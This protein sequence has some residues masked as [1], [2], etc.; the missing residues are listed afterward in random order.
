MDAKAQS[1]KPKAR[2]DDSVVVFL[3]LGSN[4]GDR[5]ANLRAAVDRLADLLDVEAVSSIY[6][7][8]PVGYT[9]QPDFLNLALRART[10]LPP[11]DLMRELIDV[12]RALGRE[13][14]FPN[15]PRL[16]DIDVLL[17]G[18][19]VIDMPELV[20]PH[21]RMTARA[22]TLLPLLE[23]NPDLVHPGSGERLSDIATRTPLERAQRLG[24]LGR[25]AARVVAAL[26]VAL[27]AVFAACDGGSG[28]QQSDPELD[29][30]VAEVM[31]RIERATGMSSRAPVRAQRRSRTE[32]REYLE[33]R[34]AEEMPADE[35]ARTQQLYQELGL[36]PAGLDL[37]ALLLD[38]LTEQVV[39]YYDPPTKTFY[40]VEGA[41]DAAARE[42]LAHELVHALQ[43]QYVDLDSLLSP[44]LENDRATAAQ[45]AIEGHATLV[46]FALMLQERTGDAVDITSLPDIGRQLRP[47]LE[48]GNDRM[49]VFRDAPRIIR[50]TLI[51]PYIAGAGYVQAV[52][53]AY[54]GE[55]RPSFE[56]L[57]PASTEQV[58]HARARLAAGASADAPTRVALAGPSG[59]W[60]VVHEEVLGELELG[61]LL[62]QHIGSAGGD[63]ERA[64]AGWDGDVVRLVE[65]GL[66][67]RA[68]IIATVWD[69]ANDAAQFAD[70]YRRVL[71]ARGTRHGGVE[72]VTLEGR[73][74][75]VIVDAPTGVPR[76]LLPT[77]F[78]EALTQ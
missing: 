19:R 62:S 46:M 71:T 22:F 26:G 13:R 8:E 12:E 72:R 32:L 43:D 65:S 3:G 44:G 1:P 18:D 59:D 37:R 48:A 9:D 58:M 21:P 41:D 57:I 5:R 55:G 56:S 60:R 11:A 27:A 42:V 64:V 47:A 73:E 14:T 51:F 23:L 50:E 10:T 74:L 52:W 16:I 15:A 34:M 4:Q 40:L 36:L 68:I 66:G 17:Y 31:P 24:A 76:S 29:E 78:V 38:L 6:E 61:L 25:G 53:A 7:T 77:P 75:V 69:E 70:A 2:D 33:Q 49:P 20:V 28:E 30:M 39:G 35:L 67:E 54:E 63:A 45:A